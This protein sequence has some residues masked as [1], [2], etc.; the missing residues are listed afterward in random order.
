[1]N[2]THLVRHL[3]DRRDVAQYVT[4]HLPYPNRSYMRDGMGAPQAAQ[5]VWRWKMLSDYANHLD[6]RIN[7]RARLAQ[8]LAACAENGKVV[9]EESGM[10]CDC[11]TYSGRLREIDAT[12][13]AYNKLQD[14]TAAWADGPFHFSVLKPSEAVSVKY[15]SR[16]NVMEA[17]EDGHPH[18]VVARSPQ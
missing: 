13:M 5:E 15:A 1:M 3:L 17:Y 10:D 9:I 18:H 11:V 6:E 7:Q 12:V 14:E 2:N 16:D 4:T 8:A